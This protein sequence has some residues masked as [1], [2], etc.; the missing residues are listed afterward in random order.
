ML[1][2]SY[3]L[4]GAISWAIS[5]VLVGYLIDR[6]GF[7]VFFWTAPASFLL[8][9]ATAVAFA[10]E[11]KCRGRET[12]ASS[13]E[14]V[15]LYEAGGRHSEL[16]YD[17]SSLSDSPRPPCSARDGTREVT[18][19]S[20]TALAALCSSALG[21]SFVVSTVT[22]GMGM[23]VVESLIFLF[24][25]SLGAS[26]T[27]C[28]LTVVVTVMFEIPIFLMAPRLL[29][30]FGPVRLQLIACAAYTTRVL[31]YTLIPP[32]QVLLILFLEPLHGVTYACSKTAQVEFGASLSRKGYDAEA[33][34]MMG[35]LAGFGSVVGLSLGG[36][37]EDNEGSVVMYR[38]YAGVVAVG[39]LILATAEFA[40]EINRCQKNLSQSTCVDMDQALAEG[41]KEGAH[42]QGRK[43]GQL[44]GTV[45]VI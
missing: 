43:D 1:L 31:G 27:L 30:C 32:G 35:A 45:S 7:G 9:L 3:P 12:P 26:N 2:R 5:S 24:F 28:G 16:S 33:Q 39:M 21:L 13:G 29:E 17:N 23:S 44:E 42:R 22:L 19:T 10:K 11:S 4:P 18:T 25:E 6:H 8:C 36:W 14:V 37:I 41:S 15:G 40:G 34:G 38:L 20:W